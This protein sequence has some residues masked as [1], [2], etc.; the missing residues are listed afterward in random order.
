MKTFLKSDN[1]DIIHDHI[2]DAWHLFYSMMVW[3]TVDCN[4]SVELKEIRRELI[5]LN[6]LSVSSTTD[7]LPNAKNSIH[8]ICKDEIWIQ[9]NDN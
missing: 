3:L 9:N 5:S 2:D 8:K 6:A 4:D 1:A 7:I